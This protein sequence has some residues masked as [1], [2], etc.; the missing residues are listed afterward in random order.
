MLKTLAEH[1]DVD[2]LW[3]FGS[4]EN[5]AAAEKLSIGNLKRTLVDRGLATDW[6]DPDRSRRP[7]PAPPCGAGE[8]HL[9][10]VRERLTC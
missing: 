6:Y 1:D 10:S 3:V 2:A 8:E 7:H 9:D 5:S 4:K